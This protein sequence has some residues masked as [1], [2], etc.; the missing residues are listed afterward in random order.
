ML[1]TFEPNATL[2]Y[3]ITSLSS[4]SKLLECLEYGY[5]RDNDSLPQINLSLV[6]DKDK[7][8]PVRYVV[9]PGSIADISTLKN[10]IIR[11]KDAGSQQFRLVMDRG[12]FFAKLPLQS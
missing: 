1:L 9:Y 3:D 8:I 2:L 12:I 5:N 6:V 7:G 10:T 11:L 4:S